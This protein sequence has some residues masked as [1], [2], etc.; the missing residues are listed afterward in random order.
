M[1]RLKPFLFVIF[2]LSLLPLKAQNI[3]NLQFLQDLNSIDLGAFLISND[4]SGQPRI[5]QVIIQPPDKLVFVRG[6]V[7]W[8]KDQT[9]A[10]QE[11]F[12]FKT[13]VFRSR[14]FF[15]DELGSSDIRVD[16]VDGNKDLARDLVE[17]GKPTG[18][19]G[20]TLRLF[21]ERGSF[22]ADDY[23]E[24]VFLNPSPTISVN[25]PQSGA[26]FDVGNVQISWTP[27]NGATRYIIRANIVQS[28]SQS[29]EEA[30][31]SGNPIINDFDA[32]TVTSLNLSQINKNREWYGGQKIV[33]AV[34][35][36]I[37][38]SGREKPLRSL[39]VTFDLK[40]SGLS[41]SI[42]GVNPDLVR[43][44]NLIS[45]G[46]NP[47]FVNRLKNGEIPLEQIQ[48]TDENN[49]V[50]SFSDFLLILSYLESNKSSIISVNFTSK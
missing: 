17:K 39:P 36:I 25:L 43:L 32:G 16:D 47:D 34:I 1:K 6:K 12:N 40:Q 24:I 41:M 37:T 5:F 8:K 15:N 13:K 31:N 42:T 44:A 29:L 7:D 9:S 11:L 26:I 38:E 49:N 21:D 3:I 33:I 30:L 23:E 10:A 20:I 2:F 22:L 28:V 18:I 35:A 14:T 48:F 46:I 4:L 45:E 27:V 50:V 19:F